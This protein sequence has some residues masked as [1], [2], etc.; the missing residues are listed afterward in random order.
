MRRIFSGGCILTILLLSI[1]CSHSSSKNTPSQ[2]A[3]TSASTPPL[4]IAHTTKTDNRSE[5]ISTPNPNQPQTSD[6]TPKVPVVSA[7]PHSIKA[8]TNIILLV[9][10]SGSMN[11]PIES[12][13]KID[14]VKSVLKEMLV[15]P[16]PSNMRR[17]FGIR[18]FGAGHPITAERCDDSTILAPLGKIDS[19]QIGPDIDNINPQG[20]SPLAYALQQAASDL[21]PA[22]DEVDNMIILIADGSDNCNANPCEVAEHI[23]AGPTRAMIHVI[24]F[25]LDQQAQKDL[26]C[27]AQKSDGRFFLAR[28]I[29]ELRSFSD[30]ALNSN[31]PYNLRVK[32][33]AG[34][35][36]LPVQMTV[37]RSGTRTIIEQ[38]RSSGVK[39]FQLQPGSYDIVISYADS[40]EPQKP[41]KLLKGVEVQATARAEQIVNFD[42]GIIEL[43]GID[44]DGKPIA[45]NYSINSSGSPL[46]ASMVNGTAEPMRVFLTPGKYNIRAT[47]P[48]LNNI[49]LSGVANLVEVKAGKIHR[50]EFRFETG[51]LFL[52]GETSTRIFVP[53][54]Y[55]IFQDDTPT[56]ELTSGSVPAEGADITLPVGRYRIAVDGESVLLKQSTPQI[57]SNVTIYARTQVQ[58]LVTLPVG[59]LSL[60]G[61]DGEGNPVKTS[62]TINRIGDDDKQHQQ[63][64]VANLEKLTLHLAPGHY[65]VKAIHL[66]GVVKPP[67]TI[68]WDDIEIT[69][70]SAINREAIFQ[71][72]TL[73]LAAQNAQKNNIGA[74]FTIFSPGIETPLV[75]QK[76]TGSTIQVQLT[77]GMYD[78]RVQESDTSGN[79]HPTLWL[80]K[81]EVVAGQTTTQI[82]TFTSGRIRI[83]CRATNEKPIEC[84]FRLFSYGQDAPLYA[85]VT[86]EGS[87]E[88][89]I[90]PGNYYLEVGYTDPKNDHMLKK[91]INV[92]V[93]ENETVEEIVRF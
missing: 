33:L 34:A 70:N 75:T 89:E 10:G 5:Q 76:T 49:P 12:A 1:G 58:E 27:V 24:G 42:L 44:P 83:T 45:L 22:S 3:K 82:V 38:T 92:S 67:P 20:K 48:N 90:K 88:F 85:G 73:R 4:A 47:G 8:N 71:L 32:T 78:V 60:L 40:I 69:R 26:R 29:A 19:A 25:D 79:V 63:H 56:V 87:Q 52:R 7:Q 57:L 39:F 6:S 43:S 14:Y 28:N 18:L 66:E 74:E 46:N 59:T 91:W 36:P 64:E 77:P 80:N 72:G 2:P 86:G 68:V 51:K 37:Y 54:T 53:I 50:Q 13:T 30:Q 84:P 23:H 65:R 55:A 61:K 62:F 31:L 11:G 81:I 9:D 17:S 41:S 93:S 16:S 15:Q 35:V 21:P